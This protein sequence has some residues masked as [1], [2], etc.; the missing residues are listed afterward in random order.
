M[1]NSRLLKIAAASIAIMTLLSGCSYI[2]SFMKKDEPDKTEEEETE[3]EEEET[4]TTE[5]TESET[6]ESKETTPEPTPT[7]TEPAEAKTSGFDKEILLGNA[8]YYKYQPSDDFVESFTDIY[9]SVDEKSYYFED[10]T[11]EDYKKQFES[12]IPMYD[13]NPFL[14]IDR[15]IKDQIDSYTVASTNKPGWSSIYLI[16]FDSVENADSF[17]VTVTEDLKSSVINATMRDKNVKDFG[18]IDDVSYF[19]MH[20]ESTSSTETEKYYHCFYFYKKADTVIA[21]L[22]YTQS[23]PDYQEYV[24]NML[25]GYG[26]V[27]PD[28]KEITAVDLPEYLADYDFPDIPSMEIQETL[29]ESYESYVY[30]YIAEK[31]GLSATFSETV[32]MVENSMP[33]KDSLPN[34]S[35]VTSYMIRDLDSDGTDDMLVFGFVQVD[36][37]EIDYASYKYLPFIMLCQ[38]DYDSIKVMDSMVYEPADPPRYGYYST[39]LES[40]PTFVYRFLGYYTIDDTVLLT[41]YKSGLVGDIGYCNALELTI[42]N[43]K[44]KLLNMLYQYNGGSDDFEYTMFDLQTGEETKIDGI[45]YPQTVTVI[46]WQDL[47]SYEH[48]F[49]VNI[50]GTH[51]LKNTEYN[52]FYNID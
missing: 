37:P 46:Q 5:V 17:F 43:G 9:D 48:E 34:I 50:E 49:F 22:A 19:F 14:S 10:L 51:D 2:D 24:N 44:L 21:A 28:L 20:V 15:D 25:N 6:E 33:E 12:D 11:G 39:A 35:G 7:E 26:L 38:T 16:D 8:K 36:A 47:P 23:C 30:D 4:T 52:L 42:E 40:T 18:E 32:P 1:K 45:M 41:F 3:S 29:E 13:F 27:I 31:V